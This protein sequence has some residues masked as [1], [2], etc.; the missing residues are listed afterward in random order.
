[1]KKLFTI[2]TII[3]LLVSSFTHLYRIDQTFIFQGD[4]AR[5][6]LIAKRMIDNKTPI[7][8]GPETSVGNMYLGP[9]YYYLITP[10]LLISQ[11]HP[12]GPAIMVGLFGVATT[13]LIFSWGKKKFGFWGGLVAGFMYALS[14]VMLHYSRSSWNPNLVPFFSVLLLFVFDYVGRW[15]W[16][17][18]GLYAGALFQLHYVAL[19][20]VVLTALALLKQDIKI[21]PKKELI[22]RILLIVSGFVIVT[23]PFWAFELRHDFVNTQAFF[24]YLV[25]KKAENSVGPGYLERVKNNIV[26]VSK[27]IVG[28]QSIALKEVPSSLVNSA[29][30]LLL[31]F[32][33]LFKRRN[34]HSKD[35]KQLWFFLIGTIITI[36]FLRE[37]INVHYVSHLFPTI[38]L[39]FGALATRARPVVRAISVIF[40]AGLLIWSYPTLI[41]NLRSKSSIQ[42]ERAVEI[43]DYIL[44]QANNRPYNT[45]NAQGSSITTIQYYLSLSDNPPKNDLQDLVYVICER[46]P[47]SSDEE[48]T[49]LL[50]LT[51]PTHPSIA[52]YLGHPQINEFSQKR[53][54]VQNERISY[55]TYVGTINI[56]KE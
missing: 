29:S 56:E 12:A 42:V 45:V 17:I 54:M 51:G 40:L 34:K 4:E 31:L 27:G 3:L 10:A 7:L 24:K 19:I 25:S 44:S 23:A 11:M 49:T 8:L 38:A 35:L 1:M 20:M 2:L 55:D 33:A 16:F 37:N 13:F 46:G 5:D 41:Y 14:P 30:F 21:I 26:M 15:K 28:S 9:L 47:C 32:P 43:S 52:E 53:V 39:M 36:S 6:V 18:L 22:K 48:T 50:F